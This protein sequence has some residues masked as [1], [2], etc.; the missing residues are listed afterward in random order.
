MKEKEIELKVQNSDENDEGVGNVD[1][2]R[3][4]QERKKLT[5]CWYS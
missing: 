1:D 5:K 2:S 3:K 4:A